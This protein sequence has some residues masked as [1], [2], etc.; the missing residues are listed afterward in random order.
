MSNANKPA[1]PIPTTYP[2]DAP[3]IW[4]HYGLTKRELFAM[5]IMAGLCS[6]PDCGG[7]ATTAAWSVTAA[8]ALLSALKLKEPR[9]D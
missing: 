9:H 1:Y 6:N 7:A 4:G 8:D 2:P 5:H 3:I